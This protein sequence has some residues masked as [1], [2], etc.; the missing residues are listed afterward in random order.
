MRITLL[1]RRV[2]P[3]PLNG[4]LGLFSLALL[5]AGGCKGTTGG[6]SSGSGGSAGGRGGSGGTGAATG[7]AGGARGGAGGSGPATGGTPGT[8]TGG[9]TGGTGTPVGT[10]GAGGSGVSTGGA[11]GS[12]TPAP[13]GAA[14]GGTGGTGGT[15]PPAA[16]P[17]VIM[18]GND[19]KRTGTV[20]NETVLKPA[21]I[22]PTG[23]GKLH[24]RA[25][26]GEIYGQILYLPNMNFGAR[27]RHNAL[28][29]VTMK[30][31]VYMLDAD[32][33]TAP[34]FWEKN[35][36]A[37]VPVRDLSPQSCVP[38]NDISRWLGIL[39]TPAI[40]MAT[41][42][43][44]LVART[45]NGNTH[46][47]RLYAHSLVDGS[48]RMGS[49]V[50]ITATVQGNG[51]G[52]QG[53]MIRFNAATQNQR[54]GLLVHDGLVYIAFAAHCDQPPYHGWLLGYDTATLQQRV[55]FNTTPNGA[56]GG[57][58]MSGS[59][60][61]VD[62]DGFMYLTTGNGDA[63][64]NGGSDHGESFLKLRRQGGTMQVVDWFIPYSYE[65]LE[66]GDR[67]LGAAGV[68]LIPGSNLILG[69]GKDGKVYVVNKNDMG[70]YTPPTRPYQP[71][72][73]GQP[74]VLPQGTDR[75]VQTLDVAAA[76]NPMLAHNHSTPVYWKSQA[77]EFVYTWAEEDYLRQWKLEN[78]RLVPYRMSKVKAPDEG[79]GGQGMMPSHRY[80]MPGGTM[81]L[82]ADGDKTESG[83]IWVTMPVSKSANNAVVPGVMR[84]F[85][86]ADVSRELWNSEANADRDGLTN[87]AKF[88]PVTVYNGRVYVP[89]FKSPETTNQYCVYG[90][91]AP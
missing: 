59:P 55:V 5:V 42:T 12:G 61:S 58:W 20:L 18:R 69:G 16:G 54:A 31:R 14:T 19:L 82:S 7:G 53:G 13:D 2:G 23:F 62:E 68:L 85:D 35:H 34:P 89:T 22:T 15:A 70:K 29:V 90:A 38:Y 84:A 52:S 21:M 83:V 25:V 57:I 39:S 74:E 73:Q 4:W 27:G 50:D 72:A 87:Y 63:D 71:P 81:S 56:A 33:P 76:S 47:H 3:R 36:G 43:V 80:T 45:R 66:A 91:L 26:D 17:G 86:A 75:I 8:G 65:F 88:N 41:Q 49:P 11:G 9:T 37:P 79:R 77:G 60:P 67:D 30:N 40:D 10:G 46:V 78:G 64:L 44:F 48:D 51:Q 24:C 32:D 1:S 28:L 6:N